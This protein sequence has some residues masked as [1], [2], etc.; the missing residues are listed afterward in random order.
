MRSN[1]RIIMKAPSK[2]PVADR[3]EL[4]D[5]PR[6]SAAYGCRLLRQGRVRKPEAAAHGRDTPDGQAARRVQT[7]PVGL[8]PRFDVHGV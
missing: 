3:L 8:V 2:R 4:R 7:S 6:K 5:K 1:T